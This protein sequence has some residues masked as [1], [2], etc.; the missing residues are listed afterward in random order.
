[1]REAIRVQ[2]KRR[3]L[4]PR[5]HPQHAASMFD[6]GV[7]LLYSG[8]MFGNLGDLSSAIAVLESVK[9]RLD[10]SVDRAAVLSAL[11]LQLPFHVEWLTDRSS[12]T[13]GSAVKATLCGGQG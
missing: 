3:R 13:A 9:K 12:V 10:P 2:K 5:G 7:T 4:A 8:I 11:V 1:M 6:L